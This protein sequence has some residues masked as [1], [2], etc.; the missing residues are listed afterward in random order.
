MGDGDA[1][2]DGGPTNTVAFAADLSGET[3]TLAS[4]E[5]VI[6]SDVSIDG[7]VSGDGGEPEITLDA[8][9][10]SRVI[11]VASGSSTLDGLVMTG[12]RTFNS[13]SQGAGV[14]VAIG[15][16]VAIVEFRNM[17][18]QAHPHLSTLST[19]AE[20]FQTRAR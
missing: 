5:L 17:G 19:L 7:D 11:R 6:G 10:A 9:G 2:N 8:I 16:T 15:A 14:F 20:G 13:Y 4:G 12:G 3:I 1:D 18:Q